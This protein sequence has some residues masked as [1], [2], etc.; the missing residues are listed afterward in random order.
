M[1]NPFARL[2]SMLAT[3][4]VLAST[5]VAQGPVTVRGQVVDEQSGA[6]SGAH[7]TLTGADGKKRSATA[8]ANGEFSIPNV[9]PGLYSL[10][11]D[12]KGFEN[13]V[14]EGLQLPTSAPLKITLTVAQITAETTIKADSSGISVEPDQN[15]NAIV[16]DEK[17]IMDLL[18][19]NEDEMLEFLQA[20]AGPAA[21]G[22]SGG[23]DGPQIYIDGFPGGR[24]P[25]R[26]S[27]LQIRINQNPLSAEYSH[28]GQGRIEIVTKPGTEQ[29][30]G[31]AGFNLRNSALDARNAFA[32]NRPDLDQR[33]YSFT[34]SGPIIKKKISFF[35]NADQRTVDSSVIVNAITLDGPLVTNVPSTN[36]NRFIGLRVG[37][38][39]SKNNV[40]TVGYNYHQS[41]R[42]TNGGGFTLPDRGS[43]TDNTNHTF[44]LAETFVVN[45]RLIHESRL[46][47]QHEVT[48]STAKTPGVAIN[49][50]D[51]FNSG[52]ATCCPNTASQ[53]QLDFQDY[54]TYTLK[55]HTLRGGF[56]LL[57]ES[58][59]DLNASNFNGTY[60]FSSLDQYRQ[61]LAGAHV[62]PN[63]PNSP[64][65]RATQFSIN[66]GDPVLQY[67]Q[68]EA[69]LFLQ[70]DIRLRQNFTLSA[71]IR[72]EFQSHLQDKLNIAPR[73]GIAWSPSKDRKT[74]V[75]TGG[76]IFFNR[77]NGN[78]YE[79]TI[80][81]DSITQQNIVIRNPV[82]DPVDPLGANPAAAVDPLRAIR[83]VFDPSLKAPYT[84][85]YTSSVEHQFPWG[86]TG[87]LTHT[88][89][90]GVHFF[91]SRN[92][93]A[94]FPDTLLRP[95]PTVGNIYELE[96]IATSRYNGFMFRGDRRFGRN[97]SVFANY[98]LSWTNS[99][100]DGAQSLPANSYDL[101]S[102][103]GPAASD[104]RHFLNVTGM[105]S[106]PH[107]FR[108]TPF[109]V[110]SSGGPLNIT[111]GQDDNLDTV[112]NDRPAG[113]S[114]NSDLPAS[115]YPL[116]PNRCI[117][118]CGP[119]QVPVLLRDF[120]ETNYPDGV[121]AL[122]PG[123][124]SV[125]LSIGKTFA[126]GHST[127]RLAQNGP[128]A[129]PDPSQTDG[130]DQPGGDNQGGQTGGRGGA[131]AGGRGGAR[132]GGG[133]FAG[134]G[135]GG[136]GRGGGGARGG[137]R[138]R[139]NGP[140]EGSRYNFQISAQITNLMNHV[141]PDRFSGVLTSPFFGRSNSAGAA[142]HI[143]FN[144]RF[145]F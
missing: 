70:D 21:G 118:S 8:N 48:D 27:I 96:S 130:Q 120:L 14:E 66:R 94:P 95:D 137:G 80:R 85:Y 22:V 132:G 11:V 82:F 87:S 42:V 99:D 3:V 34:L 84:I 6:I 28:P 122:N 24:L 50:L 90:R 141:N 91:R 2:L 46:R 56:Q 63:D 39:L 15:M 112:I 71:G 45:S 101:H 30:H 98:T 5:S 74:T 57:Y 100:A 110:I 17:M 124:V 103:W 131:A 53:N 106:L 61:V 41:E 9:P 145:S 143:D 102:E 139:G 134:R 140:A 76:G 108:L 88:Y 104:R 29:W 55:K 12:F 142:R 26:E 135:G 77:L 125:N 69:S 119:G 136:G 83:R 59:D 115:L 1:N 52:G 107:G 54:L 133:G 19:D 40:L 117:L 68:Y 62:D 43:S 35:L 64:L 32:L 78:L 25:P 38:T 111:T 18:P 127:G 105:L 129:I 86:I 47:W 58:H 75:R 89:A 44:T 13:H 67:K 92:I 31:S 7:A 4:L 144:L 36:E 51:A 116:I 97:F 73:L 113:I 49:V 37:S 109:V 93:N 121:R 65:V 23:Q 126:I 20:L 114:R 72:Y 60:T 79:N 128:G 10:T 33:H 16:L 138:G 123:S 81:F